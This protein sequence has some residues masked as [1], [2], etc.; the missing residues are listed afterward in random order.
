MEYSIIN[1]AQHKM[2]ESANLLKEEKGH[3][4]SDDR[5]GCRH[6]AGEEIRVLLQKPAVAEQTREPLRRARKC[7]SNDRS[8]PKTRSYAEEAK[9]MSEQA[10]EVGGTHPR[11]VPV[12]QAIGWYE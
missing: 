2:I 6:S 5:E 3:E 10:R 1:L 12:D 4:P 9:S 11:V 8:I 7:S